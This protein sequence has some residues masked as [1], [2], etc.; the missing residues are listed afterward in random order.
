MAQSSAEAEAKAR[1]HLMDYAWISGGVEFSRQPPDDIIAQL[2]TEERALYE[3]ARRLGIASEILSW[4]KDKRPP[5]TPTVVRSMGP[6][7]RGKDD[8]GS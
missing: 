1:S 5:G 7:L 3:K 4:P 2:G 6:P 8:R